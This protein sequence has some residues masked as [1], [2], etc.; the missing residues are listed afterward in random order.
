MN[1]LGKTRRDAVQEGPEAG[2]IRLTLALMTA[3]GLL[4]TA[5]PTRIAEAS[6]PWE[7]SGY[8]GEAQTR[9]MQT[10]IE[11]QR[12]KIAKL[13]DERRAQERELGRLQEQIGRQAAAAD[14]QQQ[15][16]SR[17]TTL[18]PVPS[19]YWYWYPPVGVSLYFGRPWIYGIYGPPYIYRPRSWG[20][21]HYGPHGGWGRRW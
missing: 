1:F 6:V 3:I 21:R 2:K 17:S 10:F 19:P 11:L 18:V 4:L 14:V 15:L 9:C 7:C 12:E 8:E 16:A 20:P 5:W 13:E